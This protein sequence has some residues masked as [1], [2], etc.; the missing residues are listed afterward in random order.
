MLNFEINFSN[1]SMLPNI[2]DFTI[3][4]NIITKYIIKTTTTLKE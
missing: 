1:M 4:L 3:W 2:L